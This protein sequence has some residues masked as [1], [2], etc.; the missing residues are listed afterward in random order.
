M[1]VWRWQQPAYR[2]L[3]LWLGLL[4]LPA[5]LAKD[6]FIPNTLRMSG[7]VPAIYLLV[8]VGVWEAYRF[9]RARFLR[10]HETRVAI[11]LAAVAGGLILAQGVS[12]YRTYFEKWANAPEVHWV[13]KAEWLELVTALHARPPNTGT[14]YLI[15][16]G[17]RLA[18]PVGGIQELHIRIPVSTAR[19]RPS[20]STRTRPIWR[21][22]SGPLWLQRRTFQRY[23]L[24][25]GR[26]I[27]SG[28]PLKRSASPFFWTVRT[29]LRQR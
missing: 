5:M 21:R 27:L 17:H 1:A 23:R 16:D 26:P 9:L 28:L 2:L 15:P 18:G 12:T 25:S 7:A 11:A 22:R 19:R 13:Y 4:L 3:L 20:S 8:G 29:L 6:I 10:A 14:V 24:S